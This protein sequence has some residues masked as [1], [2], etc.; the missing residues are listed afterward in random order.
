MTNR[1]K[2]TPVEQQWRK[3]LR[4]IKRFVTSAEKRGYMFTL[5]EIKEPKKITEASVRK[6]K[7]ITPKSLYKKAVFVA[8]GGVIVKGEQGRQIERK[9]AA[10]K[11]LETRRK[12][13]REAERNEQGFEQRRR[14]ADKQY[15][16][17]FESDAEFRQRFS[18]GKLAYQTVMEMIENV[19]FGRPSACR[20]LK[21]LLNS[22]IDSYGFDTTM[23]SISNAPEEFISECQRAL[24]YSPEHPSHQDALR[25]IRVLITGTLPTAEE[26]RN[27]QDMM[28]SEETASDFYG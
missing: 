28:D 27:F 5:P 9:K 22:E 17:K 1:K 16:K 20:S 21:A 2:R 19:T 6:L 23:M 18:E 24:M 7:K 13:L 26:L 10:Q 25:R 14:K 4:R 8:E 15:R 3:E 12:R 11:G